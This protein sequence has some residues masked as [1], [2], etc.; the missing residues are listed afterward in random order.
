[1]IN[2]ELG[3][4]FDQIKP[5]L[6]NYLY[7][8]IAAMVI[9]G[10]GA[11]VARLAR[12]VINQRV[13]KRTGDKTLHLFL[14]K[15]IYWLIWLVVIIAFLSELGV[16]TASL[17]AVMGALSLA[18]GLSLKSSLS[19]LASGILL[20]FFKPFKVGDYVDVS[21]ISGTVQAIEILF[22]YI[23][24]SGNQLVALPNSRVLGGAIT[25]YSHNNER[26][27][28]LVIGIGYDD[29]IDQAKQILQDILGQEHRVLQEPRPP[30]IAVKELGDSS[31]NILVRA[32][33]KRTEYSSVMWALTETIKKQFDQ[34]GISFPYPS[35]EVY[36]TEV[37]Q[38]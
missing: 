16:Q 28:D 4:W 27:M 17:I 24:T 15:L 19:N 30:I 29:D 22:T 23:A 12:Q 8:F 3:K 25:N 26:R 20:I 9:M 36:M 18:V 11:L 31:V 10:V 13:Q 34:A 2:P 6:F 32:W 33:T 1:M 35:R 5:E 37:K 14:S 7:R 38:G 21:S